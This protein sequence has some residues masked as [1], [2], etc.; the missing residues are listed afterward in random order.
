MTESPNV[1]WEDIGGLE[2]AKKSLKEAIMIP[3]KLPQIFIGA[4]KPWK[5]I[6]LYGPP[7]TGKT[8]LAK[9]CATESQGT[10]FSISAS[11]LVSKY[12]G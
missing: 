7:G 3:K 2:A 5:G 12:V 9:A 6:L 10:F 11:D 4:L 1:K 8:Y